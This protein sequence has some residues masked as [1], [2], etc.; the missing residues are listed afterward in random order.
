MYQATKLEDVIATLKKR[1]GHTIVQTANQLSPTSQ[2]LSTGVEAIDTLLQGGVL[3][4]HLNEIT[5]RPTSGAT[6]II[7]HLTGQ[8]Q[9]NGHEVVYIDLERCFDPM[10]AVAHGVQIDRLLVVHPSQPKQALELIRD[11]AIQNLKCMV[12]LDAGSVLLGKQFNRIELRLAQASAYVVTLTSRVSRQ[13]QVVIECSRNSWLY[14]GNDV[15]GYQVQAKLIKHPNLIPA[16]T[17][18]A[19][20]FGG[21]HA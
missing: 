21:N 19:L 9:K 3:L 6:S 10:S 11:I 8:A 20:H 4:G 17:T 14:S 13:A 18:F 1:Y 15:I 7:H 5:G 16:Q 12:I 2:Q